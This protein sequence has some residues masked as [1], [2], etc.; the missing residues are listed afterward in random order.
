MYEMM[1]L[2]GERDMSFVGKKDEKDVVAYKILDIYR[3]FVKDEKELA[4]EKD[5]LQEAFEFLSG[6]KLR[7][8]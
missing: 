1:G 8:D 4:K 2:N 6:G 7:L 5:Q 3:I